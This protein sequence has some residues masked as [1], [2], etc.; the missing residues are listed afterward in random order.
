MNGAIADAGDGAASTDAP[1]ALSDT[2][3]VSMRLTVR[4]INELVRKLGGRMP[5]RSG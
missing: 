1:G 5:R 2:A 4:R 3:A